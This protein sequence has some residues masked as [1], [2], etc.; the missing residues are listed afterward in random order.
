MTSTTYGEY[1]INFVKNRT[2]ESPRNH[3]G[4]FS[5]D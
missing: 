2:D 1:R 4:G 5:S 3:T